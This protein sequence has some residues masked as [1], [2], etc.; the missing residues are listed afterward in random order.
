MI[1]VCDAIMGTG[2]ST[3]AIQYMNSHPDL[4]FIYI[5]PYLDEARRIAEGCSR[6]EFHE[7][8]RIAEF[9]GSKTLHTA[10]LVHEG[11]NIATTHQAFRAYPRSLLD[12]IRD[13]HYTLII[14]ENVDVLNPVEINPADMNMAVNA[15]LISYG[16][17]GVYRRSAD[18]DG[19]ALCDLFRMMKIRDIIGVKHKGS[20]TF[21]YWQFP[22]DLLTCFDDVFILTYLFEGQSLYYF[23]NMYGLSYMYIGIAKTDDGFVFSETEHYVPDY[24]STLSEKIHI[25]DNERMNE[26]GFNKTDLSMSWFAKHKQEREELRRNITNFFVHLTDSC[27]ATRM[28]STYAEYKYDLRGKGYSSGF[29]S[30]N[31][32]ATNQYRNKTALAY[33]VNL[34]MNVGQKLLYQHRGIEVDEDAYA[35]SIMV[36][37]IWRSAIRDGKDIHLYIPSRR[38]RTILQNWINNLSKGDTNE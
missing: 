29:V 37:W 22:P 32:K 20:E 15:G 8:M 21:Y 5:T 16:D 12:D 23:L 36:Q 25:L 28:W 18:Y 27:S 34:Y 3:A 2:K 35:L 31:T 19:S 10:E 38:M 17:D 24:V 14:D 9:S 13:K 4:R 26:V 7:P 1:K 33:C 30:F 6:L 11:K